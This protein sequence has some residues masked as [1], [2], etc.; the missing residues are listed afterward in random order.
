[1]IYDFEAQ[2]LA[3]DNDQGEGQ[4]VTTRDTVVSTLPL[5]KDLYREVISSVTSIVDVRCECEGMSLLPRPFRRHDFFC[6][7]ETRATAKGSAMQY[8]IAPLFY[9]IEAYNE[10]SKQPKKQC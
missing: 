9:S 8:E 5:M 1:M 2:S 3:C 7:K 10:F 6:S 4:N